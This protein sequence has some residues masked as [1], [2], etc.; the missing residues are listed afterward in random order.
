MDNNIHSIRSL[1]SGAANSISPS[2]S[3]ESSVGISNIL[4]DIGP[5]CTSDTNTF[6]DTLAE[7]A[8]DNATTEVDE[9]AVARIIY[10][11]C[12]KGLD[13]DG[14]S[15][16]ISVSSSLLGSLIPGRSNEISTDG[17]KLKSVSDVLEQDYGS[18]D[19]NL[20][21]QCWDFPGFSMK[22]ANQ[23]RS[24]LD[25]YRS[26]AKAAPP[27]SAFTSQWRNTAGQLS[28]I[29]SIMTVPQN[30][31]TTP[32]TEEESADAA[33]AAQG[34]TGIDP[35][36]FASME[37]L[38]R[39]LFLSDIPSLYHRVRELFVRGLLSCPEVLL[40]SLVRLQLHVANTPPQ[41]GREALANAGLQIKTEFM[42]ELIPFFSDQIH[43]IGSRTHE[44][45]FVD[46]T[47]F[48]QIQ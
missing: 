32:L 22:D 11:F 19:W 31:F 40:C 1:T 5:A 30:V 42:R 39:L 28:I 45:R 26:G 18:I 16:T 20:V 15:P 17:W 7:I 35:N 48:L 23:F 6:R 2:D 4:Q 33:T 14:S 43:T 44:L 13:T 3:L 29:E 46:S 9:P 27:L 25:L 8:S 47:R 38:Q 37:I 34:I 21:A 36:S 41:S 10:F 12:D 24:L